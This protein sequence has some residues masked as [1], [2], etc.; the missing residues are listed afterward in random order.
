[1]VTFTSFVFK[2]ISLLLSLLYIVEI[3]LSGLPALLQ[4]EA[5]LQRCVTVT[6]HSGCIGLPDNSIEAMD[7]GV[8]VGADIV[9]FDLNFR[10]DGTPVLSHNDPGDNAC[11]TL[12]EAFA[13]L[14]ANPA[15]MANTDVKSTAFL[16]KVQTMAQEAGVLDQ[17]FFTGLDETMIPVAAQTC[18]DIPYYLNVK[19]KK[20]ED[21]A[22]L[23]KKA[24]ALGAIGV[25]LSYK[26]ASFPL[27]RAMHEKGLLVSM[28]D[29]DHAKEAIGAIKMGA[30]NV[31]TCHPALVRLLL[32]RFFPI[33]SYVKGLF[34]K[35][36][37]SSVIISIVNKKHERPKP[38]V[39]VI[40]C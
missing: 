5:P 33:P 4:E 26:K 6:A 31:T 36:M 8:A 21:F 11:T 15:V 20:D 9:E 18:P 16:D 25:N 17:L 38:T 29:V 23:A 34:K 12:A 24:V 37:E 35:I 32:P 28:W 39:Q 40:N 27:V 30:D 13:F 19:P 10:A 14:A 3:P 1:M 22:A 2:I 7:A